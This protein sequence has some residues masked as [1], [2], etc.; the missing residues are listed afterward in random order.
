MSERAFLA[1]LRRLNE[2]DAALVDPRPRRAADGAKAVDHW[3]RKWGQLGI[4][5]SRDETIVDRVYSA[6]M[7]PDGAIH[8]YAKAQLPVGHDVRVGDTV[9]FCFRPQVFVTRGRT[10]AVAGIRAGTPTLGRRYDAEARPV[11]GV[12]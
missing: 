12:S 6:S 7:A 3:A 8:Y 2:E 10:Q 11:E 9:V 1:A 5:T 4:I